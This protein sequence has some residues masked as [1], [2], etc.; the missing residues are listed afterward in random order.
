[1]DVKTVQKYK[2]KKYSALHKTA[3]KYFH[4]FIRLRDTDDNGNGF[5]I[6]SGR[7]VRFGTKDC[8][9]GHFYPAGTFKA[10]E[11]DENNVHVQELSDNYFRHA[12]LN[13]YRPKLIKKIGQHEFNKLV[14]KAE[15]S[16]RNM[17]KEDRFLMIEIIEKYKAKCK[18]LASEKMFDVK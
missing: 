15:I 14:M 8:Q 10:L 17:F 16:K 18:E 6:S 11:F 1:M 2:D 7:Y 3:K 5:C 4:K 13:E 12:N 9:A